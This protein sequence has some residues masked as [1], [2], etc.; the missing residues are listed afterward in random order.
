MTHTWCQLPSL[1]SVEPDKRIFFVIKDTVLA[2]A[3]LAPHPILKL[4]TPLALIYLEKN[5]LP[6]SGD[7][8]HIEAEKLPIKKFKASPRC[9]RVNGLRVKC[10]E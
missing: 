7:F 1:I 6:L 8:I 9:T 10:N 2:V 3:P 5:S 4:P